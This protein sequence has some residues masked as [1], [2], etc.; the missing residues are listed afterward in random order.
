MLLIASASFKVEPM[1]AARRRKWS[2]IDVRYVNVSRPNLVKTYNQGM[3]GT[4]EMDQNNNLRIA[5]RGKKFYFPIFTWL[6]DVSVNNT[7]SI[8]RKC[9]HEIT[10]MDFKRKIVEVLLCREGGVARFSRIGHIERKAN[11]E[12]EVPEDLRLDQINHFLVPWTRNCANCPAKVR[13][14]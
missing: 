5:K 8:Y 9:G 6:L 2:K 3:G 13:T 1:G 7:W 4:D 10:Q 12:T 11:R 14:H